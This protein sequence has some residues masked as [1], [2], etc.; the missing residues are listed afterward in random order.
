MGSFLQC[1]FLLAMLLFS[2]GLTSA[3]SATEFYWKAKLPFTPMP[4]SVIDS[5]ATED[6]DDV[7]LSTHNKAHNWTHSYEV[8]LKGYEGGGHCHTDSMI[9]TDF[10]T[11]TF[12]LEK[13]LSMGSRLSVHFRDNV[14]SVNT[15][16]PSPR[17]AQALPPFK[18]SSLS[19]NL[20]F[21]NAEPES[22]AAMFMNLTLNTCEHPNPINGKKQY[23][24]TSLEKLVSYVTSTL[25]GS[26][27]VRTISASPSGSPHRD[28]LLPYKVVGVREVATEKNMVACHRLGFPYAVY[29]CHQPKATT[30]YTVSLVDVMN[31]VKSDAY[32]VCHSQTSEW[33]PEYVGFKILGA[34]PGT[35]V[36]HFLQFHDVVWYRG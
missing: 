30:A 15:R 17:L 10:I 23:C 8:M 34:K 16:F 24:A 22:D 14:G 4:K 32:A 9:N 35:H 25:G 7:W 1:T 29:Y 20:R 6:N 12:F 26:H 31:G 19:N 13:D 3:N 28:A 5:L 27:D 36:C 33:S 18:S 21:F 2:V 11:S